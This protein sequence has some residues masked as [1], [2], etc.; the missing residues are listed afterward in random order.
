MK[1]PVSVLSSPPVFMTEKS[2]QQYEV[3]EGKEAEFPDFSQMVSDLENDPLK[4]SIHDMEKGGVINAFFEG[5]T[6][7]ISG[8]FVDETDL[9]IAVS[10]GVNTTYQTIH[11]VVKKTPIAILIG[12]G[13]GI[14]VLIGLIAAA[15]YLTTKMH[16]NECS[17]KKGE[18]L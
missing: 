8:L 5:D 1:V 12:I 16:S 2:L 13:L 6:L 7:K 14:V 3:Y 18:I 9:E 17:H 10:D 4:F 15:M 11:V